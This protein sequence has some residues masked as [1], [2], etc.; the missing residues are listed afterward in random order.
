MIITIIEKEILLANDISGKLRKQGYETEVFD[1]ITKATTLSKGDVYLLS[2]VFSMQSIKVFMTKLQHKSI[3]LLVSHKSNETLTKPI[4]LGAKD[5]IMKPVSMDIL[6]K[7]IEHY[8]EFENLKFQHALHREYHNYVLKDIDLEQYID[9]IGFPMIIITNNVVYI[10]QL[11]LAYAKK[12]NMDVVFISL[13]SKNWRDKIRFSNSD[14]PLYLSGLES[15]N[16]KERNSLFDKLEGRQF[17]ISS[18]T[19]VNKPYE[20]IEI[21][22]QSTSLYKNEILTISGYALMV[23]RSLQHKMSD[24]AI[25]EKLG[26]TRKKVASLRKKHELFKENRL[27]A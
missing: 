1:C 17:I 6:I 18:F 8:Q 15:L 23:I 19:S 16:V 2:T 26:Y 25:S 22:V 4:E 11:V 9:K 21:A 7:K 24:I 20:T 13:N 14:Q 5:Y 27:R 3:L 12:K 10:D